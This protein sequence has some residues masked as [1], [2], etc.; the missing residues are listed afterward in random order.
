MSK[1]NFPRK[2][3][4]EPLNMQP[5][6][7]FGPEIWQLQDQGGVS[8]YFGELIQ[9]VSKI[10]TR[11]KAFVPNSNNQYIQLIP[12]ENVC[13]TE[14]QREKNLIEIADSFKHVI[15]NK[16]IYHATYFS[17]LNLKKFENANFSTVVTV[18]DL[19]SEKYSEKKILSRPRIDIKKKSITSANHVICISQNTK[20]DLLEYYNVPE[21]KISVIYL[22]SNLQTSLSITPVLD[23]KIPYLLFVGKRTGYKNFNLLLKAFSELKTLKSDFQ[24]I[25]FGGG[26]LELSELQTI[27]S[28]GIEKNVIH[29]SGDDAVLSAL[30]KNAF[31]LVYPSLYEGFGLPPIEAMKLGCP[32]IASNGGSIPEICREGALYFNPGSMDDLVSTLEESLKDPKIMKQKISNGRLI[33]EEY[34]WEKTAFETY[35]VYKQL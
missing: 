28:L 14:D 18:F 25:A 16:R 20:K 21:E 33:S 22:G 10:D 1:S 13:A 31:A 6:V 11:T 5:H 8:R 7:F 23:Q 30:Y 34:T 26:E 29:K 27:K 3:P 2:V 12:Y 4:N 9:H 15:E 32:V 35:K 24:I 19:I 17:S